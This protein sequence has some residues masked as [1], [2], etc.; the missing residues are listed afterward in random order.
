MLRPLTLAPALFA[1]TAF[2]SALH[3]Q[4]RMATV[5]A[6][7]SQSFSKFGSSVAISGHRLVVGAPE[8]SLSASSNGAA[9]V[10]EQNGAGWIQT[11][12]LTANDAMD[13]DEFGISVAIDGD[14]ILV[15]ADAVDG[16]LSGGVGAV[17]AFEFN[18]AQ[19]VQTQKFQASDGASGGFFG[20][21][22]ALLGDTAVVGR[23]WDSA[24]AVHAG[25]AYVFTRSASTW[26][27]TQKL[28]P[29][30]ARVEDNFGYA[31]DLSADRIVVAAPERFWSGPSDRQ[32]GRVF[33][34]SKNSGIWTEQAVLGASNATAQDQFG[35][36]VSIDGD[37]LAVGAWQEFFSTAMSGNGKALVF[38]WTGN[39]WQETQSIAAFDGHLEEEF[40]A[41]VALQ[42]SWLLV[43]A[44]SRDAFPLWGGTYV[45]QKGPAGWTFASLLLPDP[46]PSLSWAGNALAIDGNYA[47]AGAYIE[48]GTNT[49]NG[50]AYIYGG[51]SAWRNEGGGL[52]GSSG[53]PTLVGVGTLCPNTSGDLELSNARPNSVAV[54]IRGQ[55]IANTPFLGGTL[56]PSMDFLQRGFVT[57]AAG[58][59]SMPN[60]WPALTPTGSQHFFQA[61]VR[62]AT[63]PQGASGSNAVSGIAP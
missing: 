17:Y 44:P 1:L 6:A 53:I 48:S 2:T 42:G 40:G 39:V 31:L 28:L 30:P 20:F 4:C 51:F 49:Q 34:Y 62:D 33:V 13:F 24:A 46:N 22:L 57:D 41:S 26:T 23:F 35:I 5:Q 56:V 3:A 50:T 45:Y 43:G 9:Y 10:F 25:S 52:A 21:K 11:A 8:V 32:L 60:V 47:V 61:W 59:V 7:P 63:G 27:E 15:G 12:V 38:D 37:Q 36:S 29:S 16:P 19:W 54:L 14:T 58:A 55:T 18:G